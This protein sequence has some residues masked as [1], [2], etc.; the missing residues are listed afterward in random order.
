MDESDGGQ[1]PVSELLRQI[2]N[3]PPNS[4]HEYANFGRRTLK[5]LDDGDQIFEVLWKELT[6][7]W[8]CSPIIS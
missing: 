1:I 3:D 7:E 4:E 6:T 5:G 8:L 2:A